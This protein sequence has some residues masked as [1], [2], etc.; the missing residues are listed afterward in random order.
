MRNRCGGE[1]I[2]EKCFRTTRKNVSRE[3]EAGSIASLD[4][5]AVIKVSY[6]MLNCDHQVPK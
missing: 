4:V 6:E 5:I 1:E 3:T 2:E